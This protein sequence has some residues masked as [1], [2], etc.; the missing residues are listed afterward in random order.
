MTSHRG[1]LAQLR[2][3]QAI[4]LLCLLPPAVQADDDHD[5]ARQLRSGGDILSLEE[6]LRR[7]E[8]G[9]S[10]R[11]LAIELEQEHGRYVYEIEVLDDRDSVR[12]LLIDAKT[13]I[14]IGSERDD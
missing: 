3:L 8:Q 2:I 1:F 13:G 14:L 11:I 10:G 5:L 4:V 7:H 9:L 6:I 12:E